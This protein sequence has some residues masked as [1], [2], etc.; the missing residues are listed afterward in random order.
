[1]NT[2]K[3]EEFI[4]TQKK[5]VI[6]LTSKY[7]ESKSLNVDFKELDFFDGDLAASMLEKPDEFIR[8]FEKQ[9]KI[10]TGFKVHVR[11]YNLPDI[12]NVEVLK[13]GEEHINKLIKVEGVVSWVT[14]INP[15]IKNAV[16][17]CLYCGKKTDVE[18]DKIAPLNPPNQCSECGR[19]KFKLLENESEFINSQRAKMQ[20]LIEKLQGSVPTAHVLLWMEDDLVNTIFPGDKITITGILRIKPLK[21]G[22]GKSSSYDTYIDVVHIHKIMQEFEQISI[23]KEEEKKIIELSK[24]PKLYEMITQ[25]I[26]PGIYGYNELKS[27]IALQ[28]FGGTPNKTLPDGQKIRSDA[29]ILLIGDPG[30]AKSSMLQ[31]VARLAP[32]C[33]LVSGKGASGVG[34]TAS[35]EKDELTG[36]WILKAGAMV[37]ASGGQVNI[38]ELDKMDKEDRSALHEAMEQQSYHKKTKILLSN[39]SETDIGI[40]VDGLIDKNKEKIVKGVD[41]EV[42]KLDDEARILTTDFEKIYESKITQVSRHKSPKE[43]IRLSFSNGRSLLVTP[44]HP[45]WNANGIK[46]DSTPAESLNENCYVPAPR[47]LPIEG[48]DQAVLYAEVKGF[49]MHNDDKLSKFIGYLITDG[50]YELNRGKKNGVNFSNNDHSLIEDF[51][52]LSNK[53]FN[54]K[55]YVYEKKNNSNASARIISMPVVKYL[56]LIDPRLLKKSDEKCIPEVFMRTSKKN[57]GEMLAAMFESDGYATAHRVGFVSPN[58]T[59]CGQVQTLLLRFGITSQIF[60]EVL[61]SKKQFYRLAITGT[62]NLLKFKKSVG[63]ISKRKNEKLNA[64]L[65]LNRRDVIKNGIPFAGREVS[66]ISRKLKIRESSV[67]G[68]RSITAFKKEG[69]LFPRI[70]LQKFVL[71]F[72]KKL[73]KLEKLKERVENAFETRELKRIRNEFLISQS[74][75]ARILK[76]SVGTISYWE[77]NNNNLEKYKKGLTGFVG[78]TLSCK[79]EVK[80]LRRLAFGEIGWVKV[81]KI[82][83]IEVDDEWVYDVGVEPTKTFI[84]ECLVLHN[85]INI[86]KAGII[87]QFQTRTSVLA[88][89]NPKFGRFDPNDIPTNQFDIPSTLLSRFDLIFTIKDVM[90]ESRDRKMA[91][92]I[93]LVHSSSASDAITPVIN[94][95]DLR[96]YI[97]YARKTCFPKLS[98]EA[99]DRI[100]DYYVSL[101]KMGKKENTFPI[102][103]RQIEGIIRLAEASAKIRLSPEVELMD[104]ERAINLTDFV[105]KDVFT[106][107][108]TGLIDSDIVN[109]GQSKSKIDKVRTILNIIQAI[110]SQVDMVDIDEIVKKAVEVGLDDS[111]CRKIIRNLSLQGELYEPKTGF[112]KSA[113]KRIE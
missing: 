64:Q 11:F 85:S 60:E 18:T 49:P 16:W 7:P 76:N 13:L 59:L 45:V 92:H 75:V 54:I 43:L 104:A 42:L 39:G 17:E 69:A 58:K 79:E 52:L 37:L 89:A 87:A 97:A 3:I 29:H 31:Y 30:T 46:I 56:N 51:C 48:V 86:S 47:S 93:M 6:E 71:A 12:L 41:C 80:Q 25:S 98:S 68:R 63:F 108:E 61:P 24:N 10:E 83:K 15:R 65:N 78:E 73:E 32:K 90:D 62:D 34:L 14:Q 74:D 94:L 40:F 35:A 96:K 38:D 66:K 100:K 44:E 19:S 77:I 88:A 5:Q 103:A 109:I 91:D 84:S 1:L 4:Q 101:R 36:G 105:L 50:G 28:L 2:D 23:S 22:K 107:K 111:A 82:E 95:N 33:V 8:E 112:V 53:L 72:E 113:R 110:E 57:I 70:A 102:T 106:D 26:A 27:A 55:P 21:E 67:L 20:D 81:K 99:G 9:L